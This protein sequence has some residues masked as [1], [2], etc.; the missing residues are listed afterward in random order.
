MTMP[1]NL[2]RSLALLLALLATASSVPP[3]STVQWQPLQKGVE[4][5]IIP[6]A[7]TGGSGSLYV[8]RVDPRRAH[9]QVALASETGAGKR[10]AGEWC[11]RAG[12]SVAINLGMFQSDQKSNVG[13]LRH[14]TH[15]NNGQIG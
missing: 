7:A 11:R 9:L 10:T 6:M 5:A 1:A 4:L 13:Y 2:A 8:V 3:A 15:L 12:L 14:G